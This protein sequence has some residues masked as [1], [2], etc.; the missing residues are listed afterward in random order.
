MPIKKMGKLD[1]DTSQGRCGMVSQ[2]NYSLYSLAD[3]YNQ[4][5]LDLS[6]TLLKLASGKNFQS[7]SDDIIDFFRSQDLDQQYQK[8]G[9]IRPDMEEWQGAMDTAS[10]ASG[11]V[12]SGLNRMREL[13]KLYDAADVSTQAAY[14]AEYNNILSDL[15]TTVNTT[16]YDGNSLL[17]A[18]TTIKK[19]DLAPDP[20]DDTQ[21]LLIAPGEAVT[22]AHLAALIPGAGENI[23][24]VG[25][26]I[27][28]A[29]TDVKTF[30]GA[31]AAYSMGLQ[32]HLNITDSIMQNTKSAQ[33]SI[34]DIDQM[35]EIINFTQEDIRSQ[36][37]IAMMAQANVSQ[38]SL[39]YLYGLKP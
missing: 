24:D 16:Y 25:D 9:R 27:D 32:S 22:V 3:V 23:G 5:R 13:S 28:S 37:S 19:I 18:T 1:Q 11:E 30:Q 8:Y 12:Y 6:Q 15:T 38:R 21:R 33:S 31:V 17:N 7:P 4:N 2:I 35:Q 34:T 29:I 36:T 10:T 39:L 14:T 26:H 20:A